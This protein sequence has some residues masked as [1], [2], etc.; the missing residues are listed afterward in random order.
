[1]VKRGK[2]KTPAPKDATM[3]NVRASQTRDDKLTRRIEAI[4]QVIAEMGATLER[5][6]QRVQALEAAQDPSRTS[7]LL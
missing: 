7:A 4:E 5:I 6:R 2:K 1:M 3:R